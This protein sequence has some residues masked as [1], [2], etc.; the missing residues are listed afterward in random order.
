M[1]EIPGPSPEEMGASPEEAGVNGEEPTTSET[2]T[3]T[4]HVDLTREESELQLADSFSYIEENTVP[5][6][7]GVLKELEKGAEK[8]EVVRNA[9]AT[10]KELLG[11]SPTFPT[12]DKLREIALEKAEKRVEDFFPIA[13][14][15]KQ[16]TIRFGDLGG[17]THLNPALAKEMIGKLSAR[18]FIDAWD[19]SIY[20]NKLQEIDAET[21][22][23]IRDSMKRRGK[24]GNT[25]HVRGNV[26]ENLSDEETE[27][28][29][30]TGEGSISYEGYGTHGRP[31]GK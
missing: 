9:A 24:L 20:M 3:P 2:D 31:Y 21:A 5:I 15:L 26:L 8:E 10:I 12:D 27:Q 19:D 16:R 30:K 4:E 28:I 7:Q 6:I 1:G 14:I 17:V 23:E 18:L 29:I 13:K 11:N 25:I 22:R